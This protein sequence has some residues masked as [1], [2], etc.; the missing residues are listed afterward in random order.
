MRGEELVPS[1]SLCSLNTHLSSSGVSAEV[2]WGDGLSEALLP[3]LLLARWPG[4]STRTE[5]LEV[6]IREH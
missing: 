5:H 1:P 6:G 3:A 4:T 2:G